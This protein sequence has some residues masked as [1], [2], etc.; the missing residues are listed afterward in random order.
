MIQEEQKAKQNE[1]IYFDME[2]RFHNKLLAKQFKT[3]LYYRHNKPH[4]G[5]HQKDTLHKSK[6]WKTRTLLIC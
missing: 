1:Q 2:P 6:I 3:S 5:S 4:N